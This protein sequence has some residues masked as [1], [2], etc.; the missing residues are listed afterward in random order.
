MGNNDV[1]DEEERRAA[2]HRRRVHGQLIA[3][4]VLLLIL[5][6]LGAAGFGV[7][8]LIRQ[9][10]TGTQTEEEQ[11]V[12]VEVDDEPEPEPEEEEPEEV[13]TGPTAEEQFDEYLTTYI[14]SMTLEEK[15]AGLLIVTPEQLTGVSV[16]TQGGSG[17]QAALE[18]YTVGGI[19]YFKQNILSEEQ[20]TEMISNT[21]SYSKYPLFIAV[22]EE[23]G[24]VSTVLNS[25]IE[26]A[27]VASNAE[28]GANG[29][30][31]EA[32]TQGMTIGSYLAALGIN[33]D[34]APVTE[35]TI[36]EDAAI[37]DRTYGSDAQT[38]GTLASQMAQGLQNQGVSATLKTFP[39]TGDLTGSTQDGAVSTE[40]DRESY[41]EYEF[42]A[43]K[44]AIDGGADFVMVSHMTAS[45]LSGSLD[46][47]SMCESVVTDI[48]RNSLGFDG[49]IITEPLTYSAITEYYDTGD[50]V[51]SCLKAGCDMILMP[52]S[53]SEAVEAIVEAVE[54]GT[55]SEERINDS[56]LRI[57]RIKY[58]DKLADFQ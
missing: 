9:H 35:V 57:Y 53:V 34:L 38:V 46:P 11:E 19:V 27:D 16:A 45:N 41:G 31:D 22:N 28:V 32:Y 18:Q 15:A 12:N 14:S 50:A 2:R 7:V 1:M 30:A 37:A 6:V 39:G 36:S 17:T 10:L 47:I 40:R 52:S 23:G 13:I 48:L 54:A 5:V 29:V 4:V 43:F 20:F 24:E 3:Y 44:T 49:V 33:L 21:V 42:V 8:R 58:A 55:L 25:A 26:V 56:L 51:V